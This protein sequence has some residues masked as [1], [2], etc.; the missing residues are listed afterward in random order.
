MTV[1]KSW[2]SANV[3]ERWRPRITGNEFRSR[4]RIQGHIFPVFPRRILIAGRNRGLV[5]GARCSRGLTHAAIQSRVS[6]FGLFRGRIRSESKRRLKERLAYKAHSPVILADRRSQGSWTTTFLSGNG[7][8]LR[9]ALTES[10][11]STTCSNLFI[12]LFTGRAY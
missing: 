10:K 11:G 4:G 5:R 2:V 9:P 12:Y 3:A 8:F 6:G 7:A 1:R